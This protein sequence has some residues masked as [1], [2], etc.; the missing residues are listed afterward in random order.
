MSTIDKG[1]VSTTDRGFV[2]SIDRGFGEHWQGP[3][4]YLCMCLFITKF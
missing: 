1:F 2:E 4:M 3:A